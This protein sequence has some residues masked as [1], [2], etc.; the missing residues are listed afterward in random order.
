MA[1]DTADETPKRKRKGASVMA[2]VLLAMVVTGLG[3]YGV[4]NYGSGL[5]SIGA[6]GEREITVQQYARALQG[7]M[8]AFGAQL[9]T[10]ITLPDAI[11]IGLDA[12]VRQQLVTTAALDDEAAK[13]G[14]S[15]GDARV[16]REL[17]AIGAFKGASGQFDRETYR[18]TLKNNKMTEAE[19]EAS[20]RDDLARAVLQGA[21]TGGYAAPGVLTDTLYAHIAERRGLSLL[22]L[23]EAD[24]AA[25]LPAPTEADLKA[26]Y[27]ANIAAFTRPEAKRITW[28]ALLPEALAAE[29][30]VDE[31]ALRALYDSRAAEFVKP[32]RRLV[33]RLVFADAAEAA[34]ARAKLDQ[35]AS[36]ESLVADRGLKLMDVDLGDV[37]QAE[38]GAAGA[39]VFALA[40]PGVVGPVESDLGPALFRVNGILAAEETSFDE[41]RADLT[42][43]YQLDAARRAI[44]DRVEAIDD[45]LA[46]G[47]TL[48]D[49]ARE[50]GMELG[51]LDFTAQ[52]DDKI[53]GYPAFREAAAK[54]QE[55]DFPEAIALDDGGLV[56]LQLD[57]VVPPT[58][59]PFDEARAAVSDSWQAETLRKALAARAEE[60]VAAVKAGAGLG[61][62]GILGV[63]PEIARDG[64]IEDAPEGLIETVF[65]MAEGAVQVVSTGAFVGVVQLDSIQPAPATG[66]EAA[67]LKGAI[68]AQVEQTY[69]QDALALFAAAL[70]QRAGVSFNQSAIDAVHAQ[71][72]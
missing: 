55:G 72:R 9:N 45:A 4:T 48:A 62:F 30:P 41:A 60:I 36:F 35:G 51:T 49:L 65:G 56:A 50:Q 22:R 34:A 59:I 25:P 32:E 19:F 3:G 17:T 43:E 67:A 39:A 28:A 69:A 63:T 46:G 47:A 16:A 26:H 11:N 12:K 15:V 71:F 58:P 37:S 40:E 20:L 70:A 10:Q 66:D 57:A 24:L 53:A 1:Q 38:L 64:F 14:L 52:S 2:W 7:E 21:I 6:V 68:A 42:V 31:A 54:V 44:A 61:S 8:R 33:E 13:L 23:G 5:Q 27:E 18:F 29:M